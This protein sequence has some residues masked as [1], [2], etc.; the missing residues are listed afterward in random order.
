[1]ICSDDKILRVLRRVLGDL[2][3]NLEQASDADAAVRRL[4][5]Q[6]FE[7]VI[8]DCDDEAVASAVLKSVRSAPCN[9]HAIAVAVI[10]SEKA[11]KSAF[12]LGA[13]FVL[14]KPISV[15]RAK[16][17]FRAARALMKC[18]R[19]RNTRVPIELPIT[20]TF[21]KTPQKTS[22]SDLSEGGIAIRFT[23]RAQNTGP[24]RVSF[25][26]PG[27]DTPIDTAAEI[28]WTDSSSHAGVRFVDL[29][30]EYRAQ[31]KSWLAKHSPEVEAE[32]PPVAC[33]L[34]DLSPGG[35]YLQIVPPFPVRTR[36]TLSVKVGEVREEVEGI[37]RVAHQ[38]NGMGVE[39]ARKTAAQ[40][41]QVEKF[42]R[43]LV[44]AKGVIPQFEVQP[45]GMEESDDG[46]MVSSE[47]PQRDPLLDLFHTQNHL[48]VES[49]LG[50]LKKQRGG[51]AVGASAG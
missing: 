28:A 42:I 2:E 41:Q 13:H 23:Q 14:Y 7:A 8:V 6:R 33:K 48:P 22:T 36:V 35:C 24:L 45:E 46:P 30:L 3:I 51:Q 16:G 40:S 47:R 27:A 31:L 32:D 10:D 4:T 12:A 25:T 49:F 37:V 15:E 34:T 44:G 26:L 17:S 5:R 39:F 20:L 18:E 29:S 43:T 9:K 21:G 1:V 38:E 50:E 19:R 11:V